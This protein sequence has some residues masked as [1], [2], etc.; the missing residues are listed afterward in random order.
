MLLQVGNE[1]AVHNNM[2]TLCRKLKEYACAAEAYRL[3]IAADPA[4]AVFRYNLGR[5]L[6]VGTRDACDG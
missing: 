4:Q 3:A 2:G 1:G 6:E 5:V